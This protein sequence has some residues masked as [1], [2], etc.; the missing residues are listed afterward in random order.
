MTIIYIGKIKFKYSLMIYIIC[1]IF[2]PKKIG[3]SIYEKNTITYRWF[4]GG[5]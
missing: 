4:I 1:S 5:Y 3:V 2:N